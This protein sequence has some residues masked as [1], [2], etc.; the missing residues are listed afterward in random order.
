MNSDSDSIYESLAGRVLRAWV[1]RKSPTEIKFAIAGWAL[2][3]NKE[4]MD[5]VK[6]IMNGEHCTNIDMVVRKI[7]AD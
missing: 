3:E 4:M 1:R 6:G 5:D 2:S 7:Y